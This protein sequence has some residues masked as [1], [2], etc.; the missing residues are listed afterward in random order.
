M[1]LFAITSEMMSL[2]SAFNDHGKDSPEAEE[3]FREHAAALAE[4]FDSKAD[5]YASL[6]QEC[7]ARTE[8]RRGEAKRLLSLADSDEALASRL[9]EALRQAMESTGRTRVDTD[10]FR[11]SVRQNGGKI[12]V[13]ITDESAIPQEYLLPR[14]T[15]QVD[16]DAIRTALEKGDTVAGAVLGQRGSR[17]DI[18]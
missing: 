11:L 2:I 14:M 10:R 7:E 3:A 16:K 8:S 5:G 18:R 15:M 4:A 13:F 1:S 17:L 12:P 6:I 9:R